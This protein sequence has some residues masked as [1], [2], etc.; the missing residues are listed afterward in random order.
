MMRRWND[1]LTA[2]PG[3][4]YIGICFI[5]N[6]L[7][8]F[9]RRPDA[10][11]FPQFWA[12]DGFVFF[13]NAYHDG[14]AAILRPYAGYLH[15]YPRL[16]AWLAQ[17]SPLAYRFIPAMYNAAWLVPLFLCILYLFRRTSLSRSQAALLSLLLTG[18]PVANEVM[19]NLTNAQWI[20]A[21]WMGILV[22]CRA[23]QNAWGWVADS[24]CL[25]L[26]SLSGP[27]SIIFPFI[28]LLN[29][30]WV[31]VPSERRAAWFRAGLT[32]VCGVVQAWFL[33][34][35]SDRML[36]APAPLTD[37]RYY[38][39]IFDQYTF[40]IAG[41]LPELPVPQLY[42]FFTAA[43]IIFM[44]S[45]AWRQRMNREAVLFMLCSLAVFASVVYQSRAFQTPVHPYGAGMR[46]FYLPALFFVFA[47]FT[48]F[49]SW[50][51]RVLKVRF[52]IVI[53]LLAAQFLCV[54][55]TYYHNF[56]WAG[57]SKEIE[58]GRE[59]IAPI[60]PVPL[61]VHVNPMNKYGK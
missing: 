24:V 53:Y 1:I 22:I 17:A 4:V 34:T 35:A 49:R 42:F 37:Y 31:K 60:N 21:A 30:F 43:L 39:L 38:R 40:I 36:H 8:L 7:L 56:S 47:I 12:E 28:Y 59:V 50:P 26:A 57:F 19:M 25:V 44:A 46:Y 61:F 29:I 3:Y 20:W 54:K 55:R 6:L 10:F 2:I 32:A 16:V 11:L 27:L 15:L 51:R 18:L 52:A 33:F 9:R 41:N 58:Q 45:W 13:H 14:P 23:P 48:G 5:I